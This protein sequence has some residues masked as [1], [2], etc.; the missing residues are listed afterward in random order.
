MKPPCGSDMTAALSVCVALRPSP[1]EFQTAAEVV[2]GCSAESQGAG[3]S[4]R[5]RSLPVA[6]APRPPL[7]CTSGPNLCSSCAGVAP[8]LRRSGAIGNRLSDVRTGGTP[9][10]V[11]SVTVRGRKEQGGKFRS[12]ELESVTVRGFESCVWKSRVFPSFV[13]GELESCSCCVVARM[14]E[15]AVRF[16]EKRRYRYFDST[17]KFVSM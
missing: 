14:S 4:A 9:T 10:K 11:A 12:D 3:G 7:L 6:V 16:S 15:I 17:Q 8:R 2:S 1:P 5:T 13:A